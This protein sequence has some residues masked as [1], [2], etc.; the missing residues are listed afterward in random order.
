METPI[1]GLAKRDEEIWLPGA[2]EPIRLSKNSEA[3][4][5]LQF[6]RDETHRFATGLNQKLR[7]KT[8]KLDSLE[9]IAG[10]GPVK[11]AALLKSFGSLE[12]LAAAAPLEIVGAANV[13][14]SIAAAAKAYVE[15]SQ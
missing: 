2:T 11:A 8:L 13:S 3:L 9:S 7:S 6:V 1:A 12:A 5:V 10:I 15:K 4:K 14:E